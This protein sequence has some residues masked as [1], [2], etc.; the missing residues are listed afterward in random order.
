MLTAV[1]GLS[2]A[3]AL[4]AWAA[5]RADP[6]KPPPAVQTQFGYLTSLTPKGAAY[7]LK[8]TPAFFLVDSAADAAAVAA[9]VIKPGQTVPDDYF[10]VR[11]PGKLVLTYKVPVATPVTVLTVNSRSMRITVKQLA[12]IL[13]GTSPLKPKLMDRGP[14][15]VL[16]YW[17][18]LKADTVSS[19]DQQFQP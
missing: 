6:I 15:F 14:K 9:G 13:K 2:L 1:V 5:S 7:Q 16:G 4:G 10:I 19:I 18:R 17:L 3:G 8:I 11:V 12:A